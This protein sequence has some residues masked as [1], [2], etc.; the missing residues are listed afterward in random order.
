MRKLKKKDVHL[1][2]Q[3]RLEALEEVPEA[4]AASFEEEVNQ[5]LAFFESKLTE[6]TS[7]Y[8]MFDHNRSLVGI[9]SLTRSKLLKMSHKAAI[10][11]VYVAKEARGKGVGKKLL[12]NIIG[13]ARELM[14]EQLQ[15]VVA[16]KNERAK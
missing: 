9:I 4:F 12:L 15:L 11:S 6:D 10:G 13:T 2:R 14:I 8:G 16:S 3:V 1:F 5:P 7:Y